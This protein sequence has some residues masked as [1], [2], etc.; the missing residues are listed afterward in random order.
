MSYFGPPFGLLLLVCLSPSFRVQLLTKNDAVTAF[1]NNFFELR[2]DAFKITVHNR[3]PIPSRTDT[4]GPWLETL[5]FL[6]WMGALTNSALVYLFCPR[7]EGTCQTG[8]L[9]ALEIVH[10]H[11]VEAA[12][13]APVPTPQ[14]V[15]AVGESATKELLLTAL[16]V[17]LAAS[18]GYIALR[19]FVRHIVEKVVWKGSE[20]V[21][22]KER[23]DMNI[24]REFLRGILGEDTLSSSPA[25]EIVPS[26]ERE[27]EDGIANFWE[28]DEGVEEI[29]RISKEA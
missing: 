2:S 26:L 10:Q 19:A 17:A 18:H 16:L 24:K 27:E 8:R 25:A 28:H 29:D 12:G 4:I 6:T 7:S 22:E 5:T 20:E 21:K 1:I 23:E 15:I 9:S 14:G 13:A 3:R 11:L